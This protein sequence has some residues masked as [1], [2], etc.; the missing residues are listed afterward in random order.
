MINKDLESKINSAIGLLQAIA[1]NYDKP[2]E[3][4][5]S[6]GKDSDVILQLAKE[7]GINY[8]AIYKNTT[9]DPPGTIKHVKEMGVEIKQPEKTFAELISEN[10]LPNRFKRFCCGHLKEYKVLDKAILGIRKS[11]SIKRKKRYKEP[12]VCRFFGKKT[13]EN[14]VEQIF[15]ILDWTDA[16]VRDFLKD[17]RIKVAPLYYDEKGKF[18]FK[19]RLGCLCCPLMSK[20]NRI[21]SFKKN[22]KM[23][24]LYLRAM[25]LYM[26]SHDS[27]YNDVYEWF[28][29][30]IF[31][32][33]EEEW[34]KHKNGM[35]NEKIDYKKFIENYFKIKLTTVHLIIK[36]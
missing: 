16:D 28:V 4:A 7:S 5:Y 27:I 30:D 33:K 2:I 34:Q 15:P 19:R 1:R 18:I 36:I 26:N 20:K 14:K 3:I 31:H 10:G 9:I 35:F 32:P 6:G 25:K 24:K 12:V 13:P 23:V 22:P 21:E 8:R 17:R 29:R 11:E